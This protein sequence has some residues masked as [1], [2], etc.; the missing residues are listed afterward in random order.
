MGQRDNAAEPQVLLHIAAVGG[1]G[2]QALLASLAC[3]CTRLRDQAEMMSM[4]LVGQRPDQGRAPRRDGQRW[5]A[6]LRAL[7]EVEC[8][9]GAYVSPHHEAFVVAV[10][11]GGGKAGRRRFRLWR[12]MR[13]L[14]PTRGD[15]LRNGQ[16]VAMRSARAPAHNWLTA[17]LAVVTQER[18]KLEAAVGAEEAKR[19]VEGVAAEL[20]GM[21]AALVESVGAY[22]SIGNAGLQFQ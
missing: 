3:T 12:E 21:L 5:L 14:F 19:F 11:K 16:E 1:L 20:E 4:Q 17:A 18:P 8:E 9:L 10:S 13:R 7:E 15:C 22:G 6:A 2:S